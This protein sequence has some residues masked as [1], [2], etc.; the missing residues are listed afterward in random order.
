MKRRLL[1]YLECPETTQDLTLEIFNE[2]NNEVYEGLLRTKDKK[3]IYPIING[4]PRLL[5]VSLQWELRRYH[6]EFFKKYSNKFPIVEIS[7]DSQILKYSKRTL[8]SYSY[9]W[10]TFDEMLKEW[11]IY[12][13]DYMKPF[14]PSFFK[15]K[16]VLD[17]GCGYGRIAYYAAKYN[18][19]VFAMDLSEAVESAYKNTRE[20]PNCHIV[21]GSIYNI[22]F[23]KKFD[24]IY[25]V[26]VIQHTPKK[27]ESFRSLVEKM[28]K[29]TLLYIWVYS[30]RIGIYNMI[31]P[32][33]KFTTK[34]PFRML[35]IICFGCAAAQSILILLPYKLMILSRVSSLKKIA[36]KMPYTTYAYYPFRYNYADWFDRLSVPLTDGFSKEQV[37]R[38]FKNVGL[39]DISITSRVTGWR[40][41]GKK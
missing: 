23:K 14:K 29:D 28:K 27:E 12:F 32:M 30:K 38:W 41:I 11:K 31:Y 7:E 17:V 13:D 40:G 4:V 3:F 15:G 16:K 18:A 34:I 37:E 2:K 36:K 39:R 26:G 6:K 5:P 9:Q 24:F 8:R 10:K 19:E 21:Q 22:P 25:C 20:L 33:R 1:E 35:K